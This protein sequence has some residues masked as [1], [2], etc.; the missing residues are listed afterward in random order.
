[1]DVPAVGEGRAGALGRVV[2]ALSKTPRTV[3]V[4][5]EAG[6]G[7]THLLGEAAARL[8][9]FRVL[10]GQARELDGGRAYAPLVEAFGTVGGEAAD[11]LSGL[12]D[13]VDQAALGHPA[14]APGA[15]AAR[16]LESLPGPTLLAIDDLHLADADTLSV[17]RA[18]PRRHDAVAILGTARHPPP[19]D[20]DLSIRLQPLT[21]TEVAELVTTLLGRR[22]SDTVLRRIHVASRGNP[23]FTQEAVL[24]LVQGGAVRSTDPGRGAA[25][26]SA[27]C[28]SVTGADATSPAC[29]PRCRVRGKP[30]IS[31]RSPNWPGSTRIRPSAPSTRWSGTA[32]SPGTATATRWRTRW[33]PRRSTTTSAPPAGA[34]C[35]AA[36][37]TCSIVRG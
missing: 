1:M 16:L 15:M 17:L 35:T 25:R 30:P 7:K 26:S 28:S 37:P 32:W 31:P 34:R 4:L 14:A 23:W 20:V 19:L 12:L 33:W 5:G 24:A 18:L 8:K 13:A 21:M 10:R 3:L 29:W 11:V 22:P 6:I 2:S 9:G 27:G 36:S